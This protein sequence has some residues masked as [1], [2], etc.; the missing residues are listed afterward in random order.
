MDISAV[1]VVS[2]SA[3]RVEFFDICRVLEI[4]LRDAEAVVVLG[5]MQIAI[6][7]SSKD[8]SVKS[9]VIS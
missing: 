8:A 7:N 4:N 9:K 2:L 6:E 5:E 1:N 3:F